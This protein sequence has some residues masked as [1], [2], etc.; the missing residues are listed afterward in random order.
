MTIV[1]V[2]AAFAAAA[3]Y[4]GYVQKKRERREAADTFKKEFGKVPHK[5]MPLERQQT[6]DGYYRRH[7]SASALDNITCSDLEFLRLYDRIDSTQSSAGEEYLYRL[8]RVPQALEKEYR[9]EPCEQASERVPQAL[10]KASELTDE[11]ITYWQDPAHEKERIDLLCALKDLGHTGRFSLYDYMDSLDSLEWKGSGRSVFVLILYAVSVAVMFFSVQVGILL[12]LAA[13][14]IGLVHY[15]REKSRIE[16]YLI[17]FRYLLRMMKQADLISAILL[18][19][20]SEELRA[21]GKSLA[22]VNAGFAGFRRGSGILMSSGDSSSNPLDLVLDY[23]RILF[24]LDL[25]KFGSMLGDV[26]QKKAEI[27]TEISIIGRADAAVAVASFRESLPQWC[28][29][30]FAVCRDNERISTAGGHSCKHANGDFGDADFSFAKADEE[31]HNDANLSFAKTVGENSSSSDIS[32]AETG[33]TNPV[34]AEAFIDAEDLYHPLLENAVPNSVHTDRPILLTG[35]NASGKSTF[36]RS[37]AI[38]ALLAQ[39]IWTV[40]AK[41]W[42][43]SLFRIYSSMALKDNLQG[44]ESYYMV[45]IRSLKRILDAADEDATNETSERHNSVVTHEE[46]GKD[47]AD[48]A[49]GAA[50][51]ETTTEK[52]TGNFSEA[53]ARDVSGMRSEADATAASVPVLAFIDEV[54]RGTNTIERIAASTEILHTFAAKGILTFAATH[55]I[56]LTDLL[57]EYDNY[58]FGEEIEEG[59]VIFHY[60]LQKGRATT[61][62]AIRLLGQIGFAP[63]ITEKAEERAAQFEKTGK[64]SL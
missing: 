42:K 54:L 52:N 35:S 1:F 58:H 55:D 53:A 39:T 57:P 14:V 61:R 27:D 33:G 15:F 47:G 37:V 32:V 36:L 28:Q 48:K 63:S 4:L 50:N 2:I 10:E 13:L 49:T 34:S 40:P 7:P 46:A 26:R 18:K 24:H 62:N 29:P 23:V 51:A 9:S 8:L 44:H 3:L 30:E 64:W 16:P 59:D 43:S 21:Q 5:N 25:F 56:E 22:E 45:E 38:C 31:N 19:A 12:L 41:S 17:S 11:E 20:D 6:I 60:H